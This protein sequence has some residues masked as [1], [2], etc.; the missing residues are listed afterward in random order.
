MFKR[1]R[2]RLVACFVLLLLQLLLYSSTSSKHKD[3]GQKPLL[4]HTKQFISD[5]PMV[6]Y[7]LLVHPKNIDAGVSASILKSGGCCRD[8]SRFLRYAVRALGKQ[9]GRGGPSSIVAL[10][11]GA[12]IGVGYAN[13]QPQT[14]IHLTRRLLARHHQYHTVELGKLGC[15]TVAWELL[16]LNLRVLR[17]NV[18]MHGLA[19]SVDVVP[20]GASNR[21][22]TTRARMFPDSPGMTT[23]G[24]AGELP[25]KME[26]VEGE[27]LRTSPARVELA[28]LGITRV[29][30]I[31]IDVRLDCSSSTEPREYTLKHSLFCCAL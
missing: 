8:T 5:F 24:N 10:D 25:W 23:L 27:E 22:H 20:R 30:L 21:S 11:V 19:D 1:T 12:N 4:V 17:K 14:L 26:R 13:T 18:K 7:D 9:E 16:P 3:G 31:K 15:R 2:R 29:D 6:D 28:R